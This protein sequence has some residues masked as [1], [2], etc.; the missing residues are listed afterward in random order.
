MNSR[1]LLVVGLSIVALLLLAL[2]AG[3]IASR[4]PK[5]EFQV[6]AVEIE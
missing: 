4:T 5:N 3:I 6:F 2:G 1:L